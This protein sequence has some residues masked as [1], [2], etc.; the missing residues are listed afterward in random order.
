MLWT[1]YAGVEGVCPVLP[2]HST[3]PFHFTLSRDSASIPLGGLTSGEVLSAM[4]TAAGVV[5]GQRFAASLGVADPFAQTALF[6]TSGRPTFG[7]EWYLDEMDAELAA[8][9]PATANGRLE[10]TFG[11]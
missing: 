5:G 10:S 9:L 4:E 8:G 2:P 11:V 1:L 3:L 6:A 7:S